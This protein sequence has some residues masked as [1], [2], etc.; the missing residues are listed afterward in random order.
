MES[1]D[2]PPLL[3]RA[4]GVH[5]ESDLQKIRHGRVAIVGVGC[6]GCEVAEQL[7]RSGIGEILLIDQDV[8]EETNL[9]RQRLYAYSDIGVPKVSAASKRLRD[10]SPYTKIETVQAAFDYHNAALIKGYDVIA[11]GLD[12][13]VARMISHEVAGESG[14]PI[15]TM[16]GQ[17]PL[18]SVVS[19]ILPG[20]VTYQELFSITLPKPLREMSR[21]ERKEFNFNLSCDRAEHAIT[22]GADKN[23]YENFKSHRTSW[24]ITLG[25]SPITGTL[26]TNEVIRLITG[27]K[28]LAIAPYAIVYDGNGL[29][30][31]GHP[32]DVCKILKLDQKWDYKLF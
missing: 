24:S 19:T 15:V 21:E 9:N 20:G 26:Q 29:S 16:S 3:S 27:K 18:R 28:P 7:V 10:I 14:I 6:D 25:R 1:I 4:L 30:E 8:V 12:G 22:H 2:I 11:Q 13:M 23:W 32:N 5:S 17:P 31:F